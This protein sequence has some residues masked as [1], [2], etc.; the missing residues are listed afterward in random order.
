M[1]H[2]KNICPCGH[3]IHRGIFDNKIKTY[4][5]IPVKQW[6]KTLLLLGIVKKLFSAAI[7]SANL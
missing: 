2:C 5:G 6:I 3:S 7:A 4:R 1:F